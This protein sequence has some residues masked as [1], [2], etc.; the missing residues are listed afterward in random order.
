M[1]GR[2]SALQSFVRSNGEDADALES[3]RRGV[4]PFI[5]LRSGSDDQAGI[6]RIEDSRHQLRYS[7]DV[8]QVCLVSRMKSTQSNSDWSPNVALT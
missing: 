2:S 4:A 3:L 5:Q 8:P 1:L 6:A 7:H